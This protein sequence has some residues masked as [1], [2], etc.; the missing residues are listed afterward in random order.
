[1]LIKIY[2]NKAT[3]AE[4]LLSCRVQVIGYGCLN[5]VTWDFF[6]SLVA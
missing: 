1:M 6:D 5:L 2:S 4:K 3:A